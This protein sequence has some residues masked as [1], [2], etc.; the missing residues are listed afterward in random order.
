[1][2]LRDSKSISFFA[3]PLT[4]TAALF[5]LRN[6]QIAEGTSPGS[7][8]AIAG[9]ELL[10]RFASMFHAGVFIGEKAFLLLLRVATTPAILAFTTLESEFRT[11]VSAIDG[12]QSL[13]QHAS[14]Y[15]Q[16]ML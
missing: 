12:I 7:G 9:A 13:L 2:L 8:I 6:R 4:A 3:Y 10:A 14:F 16:H 1:M 5:L 11:A 15:L